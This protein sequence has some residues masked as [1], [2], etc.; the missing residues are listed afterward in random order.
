MGLINFVGEQGDSLIT[1]GPMRIDAQNVLVGKLVSRYKEQPVLSLWGS[2][3]PR[4]HFEVR[5]WTSKVRI[6]FP[7]WGTE[8]DLSVE[9]LLSRT[10]YCLDHMNEE[11]VGLEVWL[12]QMLNRIEELPWRW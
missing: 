3:D 5:I 11:V 6:M 12:Q 7:F 2:K 8:D 1:R 10:E 9:Y 4:E